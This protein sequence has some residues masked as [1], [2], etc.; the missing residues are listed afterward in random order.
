LE[1]KGEIVHLLQVW[2]SAYD[3]PAALRMYV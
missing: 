3:I 2:H 1:Q